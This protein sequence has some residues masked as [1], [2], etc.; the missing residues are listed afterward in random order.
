EVG[1]E[2]WSCNWIPP[3]VSYPPKARVRRGPGRL[4][5]LGSRCARKGDYRGVIAR[6]GRRASRSRL[7]EA[8]RR[9]GDARHRR[10]GVEF[11]VGFFG[12]SDR[13]KIYEF[14][15]RLLV[16]PDSRET[17]VGK[18]IVEPLNAA[19]G[20]AAKRE[21]GVTGGGTKV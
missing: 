6:A 7:Q 4:I 14:L 9:S 19:L 8:S 16:H 12:K 13:E 18:A 10:R 2:V 5:R 3:L 1:S 11:R 15:D 17:Q 21:A 20:T